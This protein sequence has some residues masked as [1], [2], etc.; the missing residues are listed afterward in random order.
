[1]QIKTLYSL[2][3]IESIKK[4]LCSNFNFYD[5]TYCEL[6]QSS[7]SDIY[8]IINKGNIYYFKVYFTN[9][10]TYKDLEF[11]IEVMN[12]LK[13]L[14][15]SCFTIKSNKNSYVI[16]L[17]SFEGLRYAI[18]LSNIKGKELNYNLKESAIIYGKY[19]ALLHKNLDS[20]SMLEY[21][22]FN[23]IDTINKSTHQIVDFLSQKDKEKNFFIKLKEKVIS[24]LKNISLDKFEFGICHN[25]LHGG[26]SSLDLYNSLRF[27]DFDFCSYNYRV[28]DL[29]VF[30][31][32]C[33]N[34]KNE[35]QW[36]SFIHS[37]KMIKNI[38]LDELKYINNFIVI[39][40]LIVISLYVDKTNRLGRSFFNDNFLYNRIDFLKNLKLR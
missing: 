24:N 6:I 38:N 22:E 29:A 32:S 18:L 20:L 27:Y 31:W 11:E 39:R 13:Q 4:I 16:E 34:R 30:Y 9:S 37:Y 14:N 33:L 35:K 8:K 12:K 7:S 15:I 1:M 26:N 28:Y 25:D 36:N 17:A 23:L 10:K 3:S 19:Q 40:D 21:K 5:I 2:I